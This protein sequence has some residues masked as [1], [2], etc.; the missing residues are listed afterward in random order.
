MFINITFQQK[1]IHFIT[2]KYHKYITLKLFLTVFFQRQK[3][4]LI[5]KWLDCKRKSKNE[6]NETHQH[7]LY[8]YIQ[9]PNYLKLFLWLPGKFNQLLASTSTLS[10]YYVK[11]WS[12]THQ[13]I[14]L[15]LFIR[16]YQEQRFGIR[17]LSL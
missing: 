7:F 2:T 1:Y 13:M 6:R 5:I 12:K 11:T 8:A 10:H 16:T 17:E 9:W 4:V 15:K 14:L 3:Q